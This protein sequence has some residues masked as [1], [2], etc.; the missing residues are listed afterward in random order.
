M[1]SA[2]MDQVLA[3]GG[4]CQA[5]VLVTQLARRGQCDEK[6]MSDILATL[7]VTHP[8]TTEEVFGQ[9]DNIATG[10]REFATQMEPGNRSR[11]ME[12]TRY[13]LALMALQRRMQNQDG[14]FDELA[15]RISHIQRQ[16]E[17]RELVDEQIITNIASIYTDLI[18]PLGPRIQI[19]GAPA[20]LQ[21]SS[22]QNKIRAV[23][24]AGLRCTI[25]WRQ[26]GGH[27]TH[28]LF[29]RRKMHQAAVAL[30]SH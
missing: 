4:M 18:S 13:T 8:Q 28:F 1:S 21:V 23:L 17:H 30:L 26:T 11:N 25:L 10:L 9:R 7:L 20:H 16:V 5:A 27:R 12:V 15:I 22:V 29:R 2:L 24:L 6:S 3:L 14:L 19:S